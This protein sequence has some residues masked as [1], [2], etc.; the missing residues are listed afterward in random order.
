MRVFLAGWQMQL[1]SMRGNPDWF[2]TLILAPLQTVVFVTIFQHAGRGDLTS[3]G[4]LAPAL[5]ALWGLSLQTSGELI[6]R[7]RENGSLEGLLAAPGRFDVVMLGRISAVTSLA[8]LAF[9]EC[10]LTG[11]WLTGE[12]LTITHP[13]VFALTVVVSAV[14]MTGWA[15]VMASVFV[16]ARS[17]R[18]FQ[19]S[20]SYPFYV[21]GGVLVPVALL[22]DWLQPLSRVVFLSWSSDLFRDSLTTDRVEDLVV[23]V[24]VIVVLGA[25]GFALS[26]HL[27]HRA[28]RRVRT[29]GS[30][31]HA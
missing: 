4:V 28:L 12:L 26:H 27:L 21:L 20:L 10:W 19:N 18:T 5:I 24:L 8:L 31:A 11:W 6:T 22:P 7:E 3:Y 29:T 30:L 15:G 16:L 2:L 13:V 9:V 14:A 17:A 23:R 1:W 25:V